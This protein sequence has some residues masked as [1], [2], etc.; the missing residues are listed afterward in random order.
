M[1]DLEEWVGVCRE[2]TEKA[3]GRGLIEGFHKLGNMDYVSALSLLHYTGSQR[4]S[5]TGSC[6]TRQTT[7]IHTPRQLDILPEPAKRMDSYLDQI[8][9]AKVIKYQEIEVTLRLNSG[10][11]GGDRSPPNL[12]R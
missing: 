9:V 8:R 10:N 12:T 1:R 7:K 6:P 5:E 11:I 3:R 2:R 4:D